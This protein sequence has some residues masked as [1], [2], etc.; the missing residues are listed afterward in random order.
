MDETLLT[1][2]QDQYTLERTNEQHYRA[3][4]AAADV[5]NR[6]GASRY[7]EGAADEEAQHAKRARDYIV[8][9]NEVPVFA[10]IEPILSFDGNDYAG[11]FQAAL[12]REQM[13]TA[14]LTLL[15]QAAEGDPQ[16]CAFL[17]SSQGDWPGFFAEQTQSEREITD[18]LLRINRLDNNG[19]EVFDLSL[20]D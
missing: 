7:F 9:R 10:P 4:A 14:H 8:D 1:L 16:T 5:V 6:P 17:M 19:L 15:H 13:T 3:L 2:L 11:L 18:F 20:L 12:T